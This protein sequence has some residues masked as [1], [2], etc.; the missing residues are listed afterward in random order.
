MKNSKYKFRLFAE[1]IKSIISAKTVRRC[2]I[3]EWSGR[4]FNLGGG[5]NKQR[6]DSRCPNCGSMERHRLAI[7]VAKKCKHIDFSKVLHVAPET[8]LSKW[9]RLKSERYLSIDLYSEAMLKMDIT[10]LELPDNSMT[11]IWASH[12][13]EHVVDDRKAI[14]EIYRVLEPNGIAFIQVPIWPLKTFED[15]TIVKPEERLKN[16]YQEDHVRL[17]GLDIAKRFEEEG[18]SSEIFRAQDFGPDILIEN[19]LS[20]A[21]TNEV[22][23]FQKEKIR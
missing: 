11:L 4:K 14:S 15:F 7:L 12:V 6:F 5:K 17:Y 20:F 10:N 9:L 2:P 21:S 8:E 1:I 16:F 23:V 22:F 18:F 3:C 13:L 19:R